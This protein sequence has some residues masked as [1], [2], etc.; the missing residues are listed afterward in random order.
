MSSLEGAGGARSGHGFATETEF[1]THA[2]WSYNVGFLPENEDAT[3]YQNADGAVPYRREITGGSFKIYGGKGGVGI[4]SGQAPP[5]RALLVGGLW[6][7]R[8][9]VTTSNVADV[10]E[11]RA[12]IAFTDA[13]DGGGQV[14]HWLSKEVLIRANAPSLR[15]YHQNP[16]AVFI[17][18]AR[19]T[20]QELVCRARVRDAVTGDDETGF[21]SIFCWVYVQHIAD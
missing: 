14:L 8:F 5:T 15:Y 20:D 10:A 21:T 1:D 6:V 3:W 2:W 7:V 17:V 18:D 13:V 11:G 19:T 12:Q 4:P 16:E 9:T